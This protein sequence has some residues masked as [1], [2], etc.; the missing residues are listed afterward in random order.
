MAS[1]LQFS[2]YSFVPSPHKSFHELVIKAG[3]SYNSMLPIRA[4]VPW[5]HS[6]GK[7]LLKHAKNARIFSR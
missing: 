3:G 2:K 6:I 5:C 7:A 1:C 4:L